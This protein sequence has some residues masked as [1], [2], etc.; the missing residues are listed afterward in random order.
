MFAIDSEQRMSEKERQ[1]ICFT[2]H[3]RL[4]CLFCERVYDFIPIQPTMAHEIGS[5]R[6]LSIDAFKSLTHTELSK[7]FECTAE[8]FINCWAKTKCGWKRQRDREREAFVCSCQMQWNLWTEWVYIFRKCIRLANYSHYLHLVVCRR[9]TRTCASIITAPC[10]VFMGRKLSLHRC[11]WDSKT[12]IPFDCDYYNLCC[13]WFRFSLSL[14]L[15]FS[16]HAAA[17]ASAIALLHL[18]HLMLHDDHSTTRPKSKM[19]KTPIST[20]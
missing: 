5:F 16:S 8:E 12:N 11:D 9:L 6:T 10:S 2:G 4:G 14:P 17:A 7:R 13:C 20:R 3:T 15:S 19:E 1:R 18:S